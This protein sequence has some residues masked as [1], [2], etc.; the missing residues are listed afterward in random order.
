MKMAKKGKKKKVNERTWQGRN[1]SRKKGKGKGRLKKQGT[2]EKRKEGEGE[3]SAVSR[4]ICIRKQCCRDV[5]C[6]NVGPRKTKRIR[7]E[8]L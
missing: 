2:K 5:K 4:A 6:L 7:P 8:L 3:R 1:T